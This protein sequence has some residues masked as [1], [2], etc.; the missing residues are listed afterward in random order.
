MSGI[1]NAPGGF[2]HTTVVKLLAAAV[3]MGRRFMKFDESVEI[4]K[5]LAGA[6]REG[7]NEVVA[8]RVPNAAKRPDLPRQ[9][10]GKLMVRL[11]DPNMGTEMYDSKEISED[12]RRTYG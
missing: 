9:R 11:V 8:A 10:S 2:H 1:R 5:G 12:P 4:Y 7:G 6:R 3:R